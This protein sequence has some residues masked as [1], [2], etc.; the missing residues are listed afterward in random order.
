MDLNLVEQAFE[1]YEGWD[2][3]ENIITH[4]N[5]V[6]LEEKDSLFILKE[7]YECVQKNNQVLSVF[8]F[9]DESYNTHC[10]MSIAKF[11]Y[12][13]KKILIFKEKSSMFSGVEYLKR[14]RGPLMRAAIF[15]FYEKF[16]AG[17][18]YGQNNF[19]QSNDLE[20]I[21]NGSHTNEEC[22]EALEY[23]TELRPNILV[24]NHDNTLA[25]PNGIIIPHFN[26]SHHEK[27]KMSNLADIFWNE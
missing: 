12:N 24:W 27:M 9:Y 17:R 13:P 14:A 19:D 1:D 18:I 20:F 15:R 25:S 3:S 6:M 10:P 4:R 23:F 21:R 7:A 5:G 26:I 16:G 8:D 22:Q 2:V 11:E